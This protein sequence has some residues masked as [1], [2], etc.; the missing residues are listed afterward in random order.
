MKEAEKRVVNEK[1]LTS[2]VIIP[3]TGDPGID[4]FKSFGFK[5]LAN[6]GT[7]VE[8]KREV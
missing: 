1:K 2:S 3:T 5:E 4:P 7:M 8:M 6:D